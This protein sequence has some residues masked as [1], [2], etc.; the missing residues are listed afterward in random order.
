VLVL[1]GAA[2][3]ELA[4]APLTVHLT[5]DAESGGMTPDEADTCMVTIGQANEI[6]RSY[7]DAMP[8]WE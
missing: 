4:A 5:V 6:A 3:I 8:S 7:A 1:T 2:K